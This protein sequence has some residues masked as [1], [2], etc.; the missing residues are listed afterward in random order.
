M[1]ETLQPPSPI[2][3]DR[4]TRPAGEID[5]AHF[6]RVLGGY[7]T[8]VAVVT[9]MHEG[10]PV[11]MAVG[12]FTSVS[13]SPALVGFFP[14]SSSTTW[15]RIREAGAFC[16]NVLGEDHQDVCRLFATRGADKFGSLGW[17]PGAS[18]APVLDDALSW[19]DCRLERV[20]EAGDHFLALGRVV[21]LG[22]QQA[23]GPLIF[24][25]G[26]YGGYREQLAS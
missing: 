14:D 3:R 23:G 11:G 17:Q 4:G 18:G 22:A 24:Y 26:S 7:P 8:G 20:H 9:A 12:S 13:L 6:R 21:D 5:P 1:S 15:P 16:V 2:S 25:R 10:A 19:I